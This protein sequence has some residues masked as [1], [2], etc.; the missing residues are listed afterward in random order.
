MLFL[1]T[2]CSTHKEASIKLVTNAWIGYSPLFYAKEKGWLK[3]VNIEI[4][5]LVSL[6]ESVMTFRSG[7]FDGLTGTQFEYQKLN[8]L[9][10]NL[11]PVIMFNRSNGGDMVMSNVSIKELQETSEKIDVYLEVNSVNAFVFDDFKKAHQLTQKTFNFINKDQLKIVTHLKQKAMN[12]PT[13]VVTYVP[14]NFELVNAGFKTVDSTRDA[15]NI[16][17]LD[18][19]YVNTNTLNHHQENFKKLKIVINNAIHNLKQNPKEYYE[20]VKPY[21]EN[22]SYDEFLQSIHDIDWLNETIP[23]NLIEKMNEINFQTRN[24]L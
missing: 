5:P 16:V 12:K 17:V 24:L 13:I 20:V 19:L 22:P 1:L 15:M 21:L 11:V 4:S 10:S 9:N 7:G 6:G 14:Y 23:P 8:A 2:S 18:A 3:E